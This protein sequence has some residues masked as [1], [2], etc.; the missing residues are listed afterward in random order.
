MCQER[1]GD[2]YVVNADQATRGGFRFRLIEQGVELRD[3]R[4]SPRRERSRRNGM[5]T[6]ALRTQL[7]G[8]ITDCMGLLGA[9]HRQPWP[10]SEE[11]RMRSCAIE[12]P[13]NP[14]VMTKALKSR[15]NI[16]PPPAFRGKVLVTQYNAPNPR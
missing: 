13:N 10:R 5:D 11:I 2:A 7:S 9:A 4:S 6:N 16:R 3:S 12:A 1:G 8:D 14:S 15:S